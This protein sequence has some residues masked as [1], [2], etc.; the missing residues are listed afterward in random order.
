MQMKT[1]RMNN[2]LYYSWLL[3][4]VFALVFFPYGVFE[5]KRIDKLII[6]IYKEVFLF[7]CD[8]AIMG[9]FIFY[10][11]SSKDR[12]RKTD[13]ISFYRVQYNIFHNL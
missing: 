9:N 11:G 10:L 13:H 6:E 4:L 12:C 7:F 8:L 5:K 3:V 2:I 1:I